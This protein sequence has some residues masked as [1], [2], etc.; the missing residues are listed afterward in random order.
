MDMLR[1]EKENNALV[2]VRDAFP[3]LGAAVCIVA[4]EVHCSWGRPELTQ[5]RMRSGLVAKVAM[6]RRQ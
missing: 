5:H 2:A 1:K 6:L 4:L 3:D